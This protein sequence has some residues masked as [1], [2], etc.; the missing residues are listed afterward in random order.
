MSQYA[1]KRLF[2]CD[3]RETSTQFIKLYI[4]I[5]RIYNTPQNLKAILCTSINT[6]TRAFQHN[7]TKKEP[8]MEE[9]NTPSSLEQQKGDPSV[10]LTIRLI[11]QGKVSC[12]YSNEFDFPCPLRRLLIQYV[13]RLSFF[14]F[15]FHCYR[16]PFLF[17]SILHDIGIYTREWI[18]PWLAKCKGNDVNYRWHRIKQQ[19][20]E[21]SKWIGISH[22]SMPR[23]GPCDLRL[24]IHI[25]KFSISLISQSLFYT[26]VCVI[27][28]I[29]I[30]RTETEFSEF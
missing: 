28:I 27:V 3:K 29:I 13:L 9:N 4:V 24:Q 10:T 17:Q 5:N 18:Q 23:D 19:R 7:N 14:C 20:C 2:V 6:L 22:L 15:T 11:M 1:N 26:W 21:N 16:S 25:T 30:A 12:F 8:T